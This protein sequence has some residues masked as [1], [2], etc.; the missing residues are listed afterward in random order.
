MPKTYIMKRLFLPVF[1]AALLFASC[2]NKNS[3]TSD[4]TSNAPDSSVGETGSGTEQT[5]QANAANGQGAAET[6][7]FSDNDFV[8]LA[9]DGGMEEV[10]AGQLAVKM[11]NSQAVKDLGKMMVQDHTKANNELKAIASKNNITVPAEPTAETKQKLATLQSKTGADFD[12]TYVMMM[13]EGHNKTIANFM[14]EVS[15]G[16]NAELKAFAQ[17][18]LPVLNHHLEMVNSTKEKVNK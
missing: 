16:T 13:E 12:K 5:Q 18:T 8:M 6:G 4:T 7:T 15:K 14:T 2:E 10:Q 1:A 9:A 17:K 3:S 11:G